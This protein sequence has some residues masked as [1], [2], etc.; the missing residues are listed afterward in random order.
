MISKQS[1][2]LERRLRPLVEAHST[3]NIIQEPIIEDKLES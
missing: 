2:D 1:G 3:G